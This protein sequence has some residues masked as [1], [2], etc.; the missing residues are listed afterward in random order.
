MLGDRI[1][2]AAPEF[3]SCWLTRT[4]RAVLLACILLG[5]PVCRLVAQ[6]RG[7]EVGDASTLPY[8]VIVL[9][10]TNELDEKLVV[11]LVEAKLREANIRPEQMGQDDLAGT[12]HLELH[13][14][15]VRGAF[16]FFPDDTTKIQNSGVLCCVPQFDEAVWEG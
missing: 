1:A 7:L 16:E 2:S 11:E 9:A 8:S 13:V 5:P 6:E 15:P 3:L 14:H 10:F 4:L 12:P